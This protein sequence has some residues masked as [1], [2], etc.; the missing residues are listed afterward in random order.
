MR[1]KLDLERSI[2]IAPSIL[3][4]D[5]ARLAAEIE[6][7]E[8]AGARVLHIDV[9]DGHFVP[10]ITIGP[11][12]VESIRK[13][14]SLLLDVHLMIES[15]ARYVGD[16]AEAGADWISVHVEADS[17]LN[18]TLACIKERGLVAGV[19]LNP[20]TPVNALEE[21]LPDSD[22]VL[23]MTVNPGFGGQRFIG[24][25]L[26]K[27]R[28]LREMITSMNCH[29]R[30]EVDGGIEIG[31]LAQILSAGAEIIVAGSAVFRSPKGPGQGFCDLNEIAE[32]YLKAS[33]VV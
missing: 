26:Q 30:I 10:N 31:N 5:F 27:I 19:V 25:C 22:Y 1:S 32:R 2:L 12:V 15:P 29:A 4:A 20:S 28:K 3:A 24:S 8:G 13:A 6:A 9:M 21:V 16:F 18:R 33:E 23:L 14:T 7:V 17:H 11:P